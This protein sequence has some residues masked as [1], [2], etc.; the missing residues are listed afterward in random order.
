[1]NATDLAKT[2]TLELKHLTRANQLSDP[3][4]FITMQSQSKNYAHVAQML[5][6]DI[7]LL[8]FH[9]LP[10]WYQQPLPITG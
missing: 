8:D 9:N 6:R 2:G 7:G 5:E 10:E 4:V 3:I 1:L